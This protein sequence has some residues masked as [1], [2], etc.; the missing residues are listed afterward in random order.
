M[1]DSTTMMA[2]GPFRFSMSTA[3]YQR[4]TRTSEWRWPAQNVIGGK[5]VKQFV[6]PGEDRIEIQGAIYPAFRRQRQGLAQLAYMRE[7]AAMGEPHLMVDG[8]GRVWGL[9]VIESVTEDQ[10]VFFADGAPRKIEF[11]MSLSAY[12]DVTIAASSGAASDTETEVD[13]AEVA[14]TDGS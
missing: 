2:I 13:D 11:S 7:A 6:G 12:G 3:A 5:P 14:A 1:T 9:F 4:L 10:A 8:T